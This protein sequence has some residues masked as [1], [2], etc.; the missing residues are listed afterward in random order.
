MIQIAPKRPERSSA[1][2]HTQYRS[3]RAGSQV[4]AV[5][6]SAAATLMALPVQAALSVP[7]VPLQSGDAV[8]PNVWFILDDSGS[9]EDTQ[10]DNPALAAVSSTGV[11]I[12]TQTF[13]SNT[14]YYNPAKTYE[15]W[16]RADGSFYPST[17]Y[18]S[19]WG[20]ASLATTA[21]NL[22]TSDRT[23]YFP[24]AGATNLTDVAEYY[25]VRLRTDGTADQCERAQDALLVWG[26]R[27]CTAM[28]SFTWTRPDGTTF[29]RT[30]DQ[31]KANFANWYSFHR[32]RMKV[33]KAG[34]SYAFNDLGDDV[35][36]G[37]TSI[38]NRGTF[39]IPVGTDNG[40]FR[41]TATTTNRSTWFAR[42]FAAEGSGVTPLIPALTRAGDMFDDTGATSPWGPETGSAQLACRQ[43]FAILTT[44]GFWNSGSTTL[45]NV[46][47]TAGATITNPNPEGSDYTYTP[48]PPFS[49]T[50]SN[51]LAD[52]AMHYWKTDLRD[53]ENIVPT[54]PANPAF[55]QH[56]V[57]FGISI[58]LRGSLDP[59]ADMPA[60]IA[61]TKQWPDPMNTEDI[62]RI[63][64]LLHASVN[65][66]GS[67]VAASDP[68]EFTKGL[69]NALNAI[70]ERTSSGS[71]VAANTV[72]L[73]SETRIFQASYIAGKWTGELASYPISSSGVSATPDW[74]GSLGVPTTGRK[75]FTIYDLDPASGPAAVKSTFPTSAQIT[76]LGATNGLDVANFIIG[77]QSKE[78]SGGGT[79]RNRTQLLGDIINSSPA[80][81]KETNTI[82][83][84]AN[85]G[86]LHAFATVGANKGKELFAFI[87]NASTTASLNRLRT[88]TDPNYAHQYFVDGPVVV[89]SYLDTPGK[90]Y[91]IGTLG[92][93]G[94]GVYFLD[95]TSPT[96]FSAANVTTE[97]AGDADMGFVLG[98]PLIANLAI[99]TSVSN[100]VKTPVAIVSNGIN[101]TS[102]DPALF[103]FN[104]ATGA[105]IKKI[106]AEA[107]TGDTSNGLSTPRGWDEDADRLLDYVYAG[108]LKGNIWKFDFSSVKVAD[109]GVHAE[110]DPFFVATDASGNRQPITGGLSVSLNPVDF[111]PWV[112]FGTGKYIES[113]DLSSVA[114]QSLYG[115]KD[116]GVAVGARATSLQSRTLVATGTIDGKPVRAFQ[117]NAALDPAKKGWFVDLPVLATTPP[118]PAE[119]MVGDP[120]L[121]GTALVAASIVPSS[122]PC[123]GGTGYINAIDAFSGTSVA[124][125]FFDVD[126]D[127]SFDD[128]TLTVGGR[129][130][131]VGSVNLGIAM[132]TSPTVV[133]NLL[134]A[135]GSR[136]GTGSVAINNPLFRGR[137]SW[138]EI[139]RD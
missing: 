122:N 45:G 82:F 8:A 16:Q 37:Y 127:G 95:V 22:A 43:N 64:D 17:D 107:V 134:V 44:D 15:P 97:Y 66:H 120:F 79:F 116:L 12:S 57:T 131:P 119:R 87:P 34:A 117:E 137:I 129:K 9:M 53:L 85:D 114:V 1:M 130:I 52:V 112:F 69:R 124:T 106:V 33:A 121:L 10:M 115:V 81:V 2:S 105:L 118:T 133:E 67:F 101:S 55:W 13:T 14:L 49:D 36:V 3:S 18:G 80:F 42:L 90:N 92:R 73:D 48:G 68:D 139:I 110:G 126:G 25:R 26:W 123:G 23:F 88:L 108:D 35:R 103:V 59:V 32:T 50:H 138:R 65:G 39:N 40:R 72:R 84:G 135:G 99:G 21:T 96:T 63:D 61:G 54:T 102:G 89:S 7:N 76:G 75:V 74:L 100:A 78:I 93:G 31:E 28:T 27:N 109:W 125:P 29:S 47:N 38:W 6:L 111:K 113:S 5:A 94:K 46:D 4:L 19:A 104:L 24:K 58:G 77:D 62:E 30:L 70:V 132:P 56:M 11:N 20:D 51:T 136:G 41:D 128:D 98:R 71:N 83:V 60:L 86:M 91:L